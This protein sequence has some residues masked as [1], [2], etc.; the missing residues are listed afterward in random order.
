MDTKY[1]L[2]IEELDSQHEGI[3]SVC[4]A[5]RA[6]VGDKDR[7]RSLLDE[8]VERLRFHFYAEESIMR[9]FSYPE[10]QDHRRSHLEILK[11]VESYKDMS[12]A[13]ADIEKYGDQPMQLFLG[14]ILSQDMRFAAF[15]KRNKERLGIQ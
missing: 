14:Q 13:E 7:W 12:L 6:A 2:G 3:E 5:L 15:L 10:F 9:V 11:S 8:L 1:I 4:I